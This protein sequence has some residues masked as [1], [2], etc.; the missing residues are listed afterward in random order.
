MHSAFVKN[1]ITVHNLALA[2]AF[3]GPLFAIAGLRPAVL[4]QI[5]DEKQRG[6]VIAGA[7]RK[8]S[9]VDDMPAHALFTATWLIERRAIAT[10]HPDA[11]TQ[12]LVA[13]KDVLIA[14][15]LLTGI[16]NRI[17]G[18]RLMKDFPEGIPVSEKAPTDEK[19]MKYQRYY[20]VMG[21]ANLVLVG[22]ALAVGPAI[23]RGL[24]RSQRKNI[25]A[26]LMG[27]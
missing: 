10:L 8:F 17:V 2:T 13:V 7:W 21:T 1:T 15:A 19:V 27:K 14:G 23:G 25:V 6:R 11:R 16:A 5:D 4:H 9:R 3:G 24:M 20:R 22:A 12:K 26:R 18:R